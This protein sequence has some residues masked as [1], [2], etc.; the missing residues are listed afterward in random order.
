[1]ANT[2]TFI[3]TYFFMTEKNENLLTFVLVKK[4]HVNALHAGYF[5]MLLLLS[6]DFFQN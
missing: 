1:M 6:A 5:F 3:L 2:T 4:S